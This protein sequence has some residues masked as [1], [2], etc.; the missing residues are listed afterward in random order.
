MY[1]LMLLLVFWIA[2]V[3]LVVPLMLW[4]T[5]RRYD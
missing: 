2:Q 4:S 1:I 3:A 5:L